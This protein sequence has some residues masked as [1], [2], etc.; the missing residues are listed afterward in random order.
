VIREA[1]LREAAKSV[2]ADFVAKKSFAEI[3]IPFG[4]SQ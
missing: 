2:E 3:L 1:E 4:L